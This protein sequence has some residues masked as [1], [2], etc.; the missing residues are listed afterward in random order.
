MN[1]KRPGE[2]WKPARLGMPAAEFLQLALRMKLDGVVLNPAGPHFVL[3][4]DVLLELL[5]RAS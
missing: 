1:R 4:K 5:L 2:A 3:E